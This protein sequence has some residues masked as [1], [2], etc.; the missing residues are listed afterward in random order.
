M[1][2][3]E[4]LLDTIKANSDQ[5]N[6]AELAKPITVKVLEVKRGA[7]KEQPV[8]IKIDGGYQEF[9][10]CKTTRRILIG[11]WGERGSDWVG[12]SMTLYCDESVKY[13]GVAV[14]GIRISHMSDIDSDLTFSVNLTR[15]KKGQVTVKKLVIATPKEYPADQ[16]AKNLPAWKKAIADG[17]ISGEQVIARAE[18]VGRLSDEQKAAI[19]A[20]VETQQAE[21][22]DQ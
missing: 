3:V 20:P 13:G 15:G 19:I 11:A 9:R 10:P 17:K 7:S 5:L 6:A 1:S 12:K 22:T 8:S 14:G 21:G 16:F 18:Q 2:G 4:N